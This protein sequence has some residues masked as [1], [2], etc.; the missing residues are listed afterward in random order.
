V[1]A[2]LR[3]LEQRLGAVDDAARV[4]ALLELRDDLLVHDAL[5]VVVAVVA[6]VGAEFD[7]RAAVVH[8]HQQQDS[9]VRAQLESQRADV[10]G[11]E[12]A[13]RERLDAGLAGVGRLRNRHHDERGVVLRE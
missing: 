6:P 1:R 5:G 4:V 11:V 7:A 2:R 12:P 8:R 10:P 3:H 9:L 13:P